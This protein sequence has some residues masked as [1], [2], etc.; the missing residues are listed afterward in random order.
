MLLTNRT[1]TWDTCHD[2]CQIGNESKNLFL[3]SYVEL[4]T[5]PCHVIVRPRL[6]SVD[7]VVAGGPK[8]PPARA[9]G[10]VL[11][12]Y[13]FTVLLQL[14]QLIGPALLREGED[15]VRVHDG[16][17]VERLF[18]PT[19]QID[20]LPPAQ[21]AS[22]AESSVDG[23]RFEPNHRWTVVGLSRITGGRSSV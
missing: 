22:R 6:A 11:Q 4:V 20:V 19:H 2:R 5:A 1:P 3:S 18:D 14:G 12:F 21:R 9:A 15:L 7:F 13:S 10:T 17:G 16:V 23:R 8:T